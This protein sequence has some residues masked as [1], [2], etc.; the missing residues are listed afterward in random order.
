MR[1]I[2]HEIS[3][4]AEEKLTAAAKHFIDYIAIG[5]VQNLVGYPDVWSFEKKACYL[6]SLI[7]ADKSKIHP[8]LMNMKQ[9]AWPPNKALI[10]E[11]LKHDPRYVTSDPYDYLRLCRNVIKHWAKFSNKVR[12]LK[13]TEKFFLQWGLPLLYS[14][15]KIY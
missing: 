11:L 8:L 6:F 10:K 5:N 15:S 3:K 4:H 1:D 2:F 13:V 9:F 14:G 7:S 12:L